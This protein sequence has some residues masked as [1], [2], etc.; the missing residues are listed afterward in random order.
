MAARVA[1]LLCLAAAGLPGSLAGQQAP[2]TYSINLNDRADDLFKVAVAVSGLTADNAVYQF[3]A[4]APGTYQVMDIGRFVRSFQAFDGGGKPVLVKRVSVNQ[5]R[6]SD[7]PQV[8]TIRYTIAETWDTEVKRHP[9]YLMCGTSIEGDHV[10]INPHAVIGYPTGLQAAPVSLQ[11]DY[12]SEWKVGTALERRNRRE[13]R[14]RSYD[15]LVDSPILLGRLSEA[16]TAVTGVPI[17][18]YTYSKTDKIKSAQLLEAMD[19]ML[20]AAGR[21]LGKLP[22]DRYIFLYHFE[23]QSAGAWEHALSSEY[24]FEE[25]EFTDSLGR[26]LTDIAAHEFFHIVTPLNIHSEVIERFN[27]VTPVPSQHLWLYEG[28]TEWAAHAM[29]LRT[30]LKSVNE[31]LETIVHKMQ[32]DRNAFDSSY[33]LRELALTSYSDSGQKQYGNIY[34][35]GALAAGLLDI[36]L[37]ELSRGQRGLRDVIMELT[38]RYGKQRAFPESSFIDTLVAMT[39]PEVGDFFHRYVWQSEELPIEEYYGKLGIRLIEDREGRPVRLEMDSTPTPAQRRLREAWL[40]RKP[41]RGSELSLVVAI[42]VDQLRPD[43][44]RRFARQFSGGFRRLLDRG[45]FFEQGRQNHAISETAPGHSTILSGREPRRTGIVD[46]EHGVQDP[47]APLLGS[48]AAPGASPRNFRGTTLYDWMLAGDPEARL[49]SVSRK[50]RGAILMAGSARGE[51]YWYHEGRFT[52]SRYYADSLPRWVGAFNARRG[53]QRLAGT[54]W[55]LLLPSS[56]YPEPDRLPFENG[57]QDVAFPHAL[58]GTAE[59]AARLLANYPWMDSLT[60]AFAL[61]GVRVMG[62][63]SRGQPDLLTVSFS[64]TDAVGHAFGPD[65]RELH[66]QL[67]RLDRWLGQFLDSLAVLVPAEQTLVVLTADHGVQSFPER[68]EAR[69]PADGGRVW[70][71]DLGTAAGTELTR[72]TRYDFNLRFGSGLLAA[73]TLALHARGVPVDSLARAIAAEARKRPG[74]RRVFTPATL[75]AAAAADPD[76]VLWRNQLPPGFGWLI[77]AVIEPSFIWSAPGATYADHGSTAPLDI[78]VPIGFLGRGIGHRTVRRTVNTVDI[79]PTLAALL[80]IRPTEPLDGRVLPEV[81]GA[82]AR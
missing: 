62:L 25:T 59:Q 71:G 68:A 61:E 3:A 69:G 33:S 48:A 7:A 34:M 21:F 72:R 42:S 5:W 53:P 10:L 70:L 8:R 79:A 13:Y 18:I 11:L 54:I 55:N 28:T 39:Y 49:L 15:Q 31:Y 1:W 51:V 38:R 58:P 57:G 66:D 20:E 80:G 56:E 37:L 45:T 32:I 81:V 75:R 76:A 22:V 35:R 47:T 9:V 43:Y 36:R 64:T 26:Q 14:A 29:Q 52:T 77:C 50:D 67:L 65:S 2:L 16:R 27:F 30:G 46:N 6:L 44:F 4:T 73:D 40:G 82:G 74:V 60:A 24:V 17:E 12:P 63:G 78:S 23:D 41:G 19:G